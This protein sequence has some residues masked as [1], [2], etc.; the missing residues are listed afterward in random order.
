LRAGIGVAA[1]G[2]FVMASVFEPTTGTL[3]RPQPDFRAATDYVRAATR[4]DERLLVWGWA[5]GMYVAADRCPSTRFV[6]AHIFVGFDAAHSSWHEV[7]EAWPMLLD[8]LGREPPRFILDTS[9]G[10]YNFD[11]F[12][13]QRYPQLWDFVKTRYFLDRTVEGIKIYRRI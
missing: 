9:G 6:Y 13:M 10:G 11:P 5:P 4:P 8:D 7:P 1:A 2:F 12:P 3:W